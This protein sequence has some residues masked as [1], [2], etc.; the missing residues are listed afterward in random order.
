MM[1]ENRF[2]TMADFI[3]TYIESQP[4]TKKITSKKARIA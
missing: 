1:L 4:K 3:T 2:T